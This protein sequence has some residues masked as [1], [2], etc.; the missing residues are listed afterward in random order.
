VNIDDLEY[1][2]SMKEL[3]A[4]CP[5]EAMLKQCNF[6]TPNI[7]EKVLEAVPGK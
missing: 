2:A 4:S 5:K 6:H 3:Q 1:D 7:K